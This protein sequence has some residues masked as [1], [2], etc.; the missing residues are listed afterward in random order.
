MPAFLFRI[1]RHEYYQVYASTFAEARRTLDD[2][3]DLTA[4]DITQELQT[5]E[6]LQPTLELMEIREEIND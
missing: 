5:L 2:C 3:D 6:D 4:F 1:T